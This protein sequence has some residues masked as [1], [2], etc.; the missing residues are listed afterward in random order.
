MLNPETSSGLADLHRHLDGSL[1]EHTLR[2]WANDS[3]VTI[4][5][6]LHFTPGMGLQPALDLF[7]FT[8][9]LLQDPAH[10]TC[11]A[12][13][14]CEDAAQE[15]VTTLEIRFAPQLHTGASMEAIIDAA[16]AGI[17]GR[18]G[19]IL[20]GLYGDAPQTL[21]ALVRC[22]HTRPGVV[23][24]DLAGAPL[25]THTYGL[26]DYAKAFGRARDAGL[27]RTVHAAEGRSPEEIRIAIE[28]LHANRIGHATTLLDNASVVECVLDHHILIEAC[29]TSNV[30]T[31]VI[32]SV[33]Q[34]PLKKWLELGI[35]VCICTDNTLFSQV[36]SPE[37]HRRILE[38]PALNTQD[39]QRMVTMGHKGAFK[40]P[41]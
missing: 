40:R 14:L 27:G 13:E 9:S 4:P 7:K 20:C 6:P 16:L 35:S 17:D 2:R 1:R 37:E 32:D 12:S 28:N 3:G 41:S 39:V 31:G 8:L 23:G 19:L 30:H 22:G 36:D 5:D 24:L 26:T 10:V 11:A 18:A 34:H 38:I 33:A 15:G 25:P 21:E 29:P